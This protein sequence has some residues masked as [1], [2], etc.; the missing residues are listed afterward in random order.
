LGEPLPD[1]TLMISAE[2]TWRN[3]LAYRFTSNSLA[4]FSIG[5]SAPLKFT[6]DFLWSNEELG[7]AWTEIDEDGRVTYVK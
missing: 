4:Q 2:D 5:A 3:I 6:D 1:G 7:I